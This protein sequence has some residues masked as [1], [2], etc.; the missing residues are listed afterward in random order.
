MIENPLFLLR[1]FISRKPFLMG[2]MLA[3]V[4]FSG[5]IFERKS[6]SD[7][8]KQILSKKHNDTALFKKIKYYRY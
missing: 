5:H 3:V 1:Y 2:F 4:I 6:L 7:D 8:I